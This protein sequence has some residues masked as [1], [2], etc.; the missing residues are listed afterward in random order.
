M[1]AGAED[2]QARKDA[3]WAAYQAQSRRTGQKIQLALVPLW[4]ASALFW[5]F[6]PQADAVV[7]WLFTALAILWLAFAVVLWRQ[8]RRPVPPVPGTGEAPGR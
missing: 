5:W 7:R 1:T 3:R 8:L 2:E 4:V 6:D